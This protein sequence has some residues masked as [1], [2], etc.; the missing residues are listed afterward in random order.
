MLL[1]GGPKAGSIENKVKL[2]HFA[3]RKVNPK[4]FQVLASAL[5]NGKRLR[6][7]YFVGA[8][9]ETTERIVSPQQLVHY[10]DN[11]LLDAW[12]HTR[13]ALRSF[14][15]ESIKLAIE[16]DE[17]SVSV[18][19]EAMKAHFQGGYG[20]FAGEANKRARL[21]FSPRSAIVVSLET[22]HPDQSFSWLPDGS[23]L[24]EVPYSNDHELVM[25][26]LRHGAGVEVLEPPELRRKVHEALCAAAKIYEPLANV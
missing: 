2:I 15:L 25:D 17:A 22:W 24:L 26:L 18:P 14:S 23:Y 8:R 9:Q 1:V 11:W 20:I 6:I 16:L 5:I 10:R 3:P 19:A 21:K 7:N 4:H 12:C 13:E